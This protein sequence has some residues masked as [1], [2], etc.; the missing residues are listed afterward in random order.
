MVRKSLPYMGIGRKAAEETEPDWEIIISSRGTVGP[1]L[2]Y[3]ANHHRITEIIREAI[4]KAEEKATE[5]NAIR[6]AL[7]ELSELDDSG[8]NDI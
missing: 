5:E 2:V 3:G 8:N 4:R 6:D 7:K 1:R